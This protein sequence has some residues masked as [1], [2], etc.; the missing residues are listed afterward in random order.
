MEFTMKKPYLIALT[1]DNN[2]SITG[3][4]TDNEHDL[5]VKICNDL[6]KAARD[7]CASIDIYEIDTARKMK[8]INK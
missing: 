1:A 7:Y 2:H 4:L 5:I 3:K 8:R 6:N